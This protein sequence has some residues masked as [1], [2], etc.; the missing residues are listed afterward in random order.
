MKKGVFI[1]ALGLI[2]AAVAYSCI[3]FVC[4]S[5][6]RR[7]Q[8]CERPELAWLKDEFKL[9]DAEF[10]HVSELHAAYLPQCRELCLQIDEENT[11]LQKL[12]DGSTNVTPEI[13]RSLAEA[14]RLR[15][16]CQSRMLGHFFEVSRAM[17][18]EQGKRYLA[19][20]KEKAFAPNFDMPKQ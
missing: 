19:W 12:L 10:K 14:S 3:Y 16:E 4:S 17:P 18:S 9:T 13:E 15:A 2:A 5:P 11:R 7:L 20:V 1:L 8:T 6:A